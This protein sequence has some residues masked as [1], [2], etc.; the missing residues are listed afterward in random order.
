[1]A[2]AAPPT[3]RLSALNAV[4]TGEF[5]S[6]LSGVYESSPWIPEAAAAQRP[7]ASLSAL[8]T[9]LA[10]VVAGAGAAKQMELI[11]AHPA[12]ALRDPA[13]VAG[14]TANSKMEQTRSG[15]TALT[16]DARAQFARYSAQYHARHGF[17]FIVAVLALDRD[18]IVRQ[19]GE[20]SFNSTE[21]ETRRAL[22]EIDR[23]AWLRLQ[24]LVLDDLSSS[25]APSA[26]GPDS[27]PLGATRSSAGTR[28][29]DCQYGKSRVR[30]L[31]V[32]RDT[33]VH[34]V[35][36]VDVQVLLRG[37]LQPSFT[38]GDNALVV[39]T[40]TCKNTVLVLA[41]ESLVESIE[42][43]AMRIG[44]HFLAQY[45][46]ISSVDVRMTEKI[47]ER[48]SVATEAT[49]GV[50]NGPARP[51]PHTFQQRGPERP[52]VHAVATRQGVWLESGVADYTV[53]KSTASGFENFPRGDGMTTLAETADRILGTK[54]AATWQWASVPRGGFRAANA[55]L[56]EWMLVRFASRYSVSVQAT[57]Y[58]MCLDAL[59]AVPEIASIKITLPNVH[60][61]PFNMAPFNLRQWRD[62]PN[63]RTS[64]RLIWL[65]CEWFCCMLTV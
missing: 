53:L 15:L 22:S 21:V 7:F 39:P 46:H 26:S 65:R 14:L 5:A 11:R 30:V 16:D 2:A 13:A 45:A 41:R 54:I 64:M 56:L 44:A 57:E 47:W 17:P 18:A 51:H 35:C 6:A 33:P 20:R 10:G 1:M 63:R 12:L 40:D 50:W 60:F 48:M 27:Q 62:L 25:A 8:A 58:E 38:R 28:I 61:L 4:P 59:A 49:P 29:V 24:R 42:D 37:A 32:L 9:A 3:L 52:S 55:R 36:E 43:F 34:S 23:I 31:K 19:F